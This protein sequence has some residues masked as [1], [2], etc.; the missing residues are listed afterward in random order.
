MLIPE[1]SETPAAET[2]AT[3]APA[4]V[5]SPAADRTSWGC[6]LLLVGAGVVGAIQVGKPIAAL[7]AI[8]AEFGLS[9]VAAGWTV[10]IV[11]LTGAL[12]AMPFG[13]WADRFGHRRSVLLGLALLAVCGA[14]GALA[15]D[16][17][18]L[19]ASRFGEGFGFTLTAL[20]APALLHSVTSARHHGVMFGLFSAFMPLGTAISSVI[21]AP[22][23]ADGGWRLLWWVCAALAALWLPLV[24][25]ATRRT[26]PARMRE[27]TRRVRAQVR[28]VITAPGVPVLTAIFAAYTAQYLALTTF[29]PGLLTGDFGLSRSMADLC[30]TAVSLLNAVGSVLGGWLSGRLLPRWLLIASAGLV[31]LGCGTALYADG[32]PAWISAPCLGLFFLVGGIIPAV[33]FGLAPRFAPGPGA[34][35]ATI[36]L[37]TQGAMVGLLIGPPAAAT[38]VTA[39]GNPSAMIVFFAVA[40]AATV[41]GA[42]LLRGTLWGSRM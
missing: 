8:R 6:G 22:L 3:A 30:I 37:V 28:E 38:M 7:P 9:L 19:L 29:L 34:M 39:M 41:T 24:A 5:P 16:A 11:S 12:T 13:I 23:L 20:A 18:V 25:L 32:V 15:P 14:I 2:A 36:G 21:S 42:L 33:L 17:P 27:S 26:A 4:S 31:L 1:Y 10:S 40:A 35:G